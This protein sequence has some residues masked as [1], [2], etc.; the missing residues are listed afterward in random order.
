MVRFQSKTLL[1]RIKT[2]LFRFKMYFLSPNNTFLVQIF[3]FSI[4][5]SFRRKL[6]FF[7]PN[8]YFSVQIVRFQA[9]TLLFSLKRSFFVPNGTFSVQNFNRPFS[10]WRHFT[11]TSR[12][13]F[14]CYCSLGRAKNNS[15]N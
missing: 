10:R 4:S 5:S 11:T 9:K 13:H 7:S 8:I 2:L 3:T 6:Y 1:F 12:I 14:V 15:S